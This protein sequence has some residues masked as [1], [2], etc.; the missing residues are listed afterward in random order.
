MEKILF[1]SCILFCAVLPG[2]AQN[3]PAPTGAYQI[4]HH[5]Y[6]WTDA[7]RT[8]ILSPDSSKRRLVADVWYPAEASTNA[9]T[10]YLDTM[11]FYHAFGASGLRSFLGER[12][13]GIIRSGAVHTHAKEDAAF[14]HR[15]GKVPVIFFSHGMGMITQ[16]YTA[17]IEELVSHG[18]LVVALTHPY[19][20][21]LVSFG[22][23]D[24]ITIERKQRAQAG[25]TEEAHIAY[26]NKR[27]E[28]WAADISFALDQITAL[29]KK[30]SH[31]PFTGHID[32]SKVGA[33]GHSVGGRAAARACQLDN[34]I[35]ACADQDGVAMMLPYYIAANGSGMKQPFLLFERDRNQ[36]PTDEDLRQMKMSRKE[37]EDLVSQ[38]R[39]G[40]EA[41]LRATGG[42]YHVLLQFDSSTHMSFSDLP[43][44]DAKN[45]VQLA[46]ATR[47]LKVTCRYTNEF[48]DKTLRG[49]PAPLYEGNIKLPYIELVQKYPPQ[50]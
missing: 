8:E 2:A 13:A 30:G 27:V 47:V 5:R 46:S 6:E 14:D 22:G 9:V 44:L 39:A 18:C 11:S 3:L 42:S 7:T 33:M 38:L 15:I 26:E 19:D 29:N 43:I 34:R 41:T 23:T 24:F 1:F 40:K 16:V 49:M 45:N 17:Q 28:V 32:L 4:G 21:W 10:P 36:P 37:V 25:T 50:Q 12:A 35:K 20:S 31:G 48:F